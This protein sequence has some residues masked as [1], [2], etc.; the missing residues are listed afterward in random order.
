MLSGQWLLIQK[1]ELVNCVQIMAD[2]DVYSFITN[3]QKK[4]QSTARSTSAA[5]S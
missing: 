4:H 3:T 2:A 5:L 1:I